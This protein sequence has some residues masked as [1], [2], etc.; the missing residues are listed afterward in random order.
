MDPANQTPLDYY[1]L[2]RI[3]LEKAKIQ[4]AEANGLGFDGYR[5]DTLDHLYDSL[6]P[7]SVAEV[8]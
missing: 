8:G 2:P 7:V 5:F 6:K 4:L 3:D 1:L